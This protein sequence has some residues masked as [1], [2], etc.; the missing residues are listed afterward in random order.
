MSVLAQALFTLVRGHFMSLSFLSARHKLK[1]DL[2]YRIYE[3]LGWLE[4]GDVV[5]GD[6]KGGL[7]GDVPCG[8]LGPVLDDEAAESAKVYRVALAYR[9]L[10]ALHKSLYNCLNGCFLN[11]GSLCYFIYYFSFSHDF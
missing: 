5:C 11:A 10:Y 3:S 9:I 2:F 8:F 6:G 4:S 1:Y 7:L